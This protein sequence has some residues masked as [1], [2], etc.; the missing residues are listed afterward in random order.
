MFRSLELRLQHN[1]CT[2]P[3]AAKHTERMKD[4]L[5]SKAFSVHIFV[6]LLLLSVQRDKLGQATMAT[7]V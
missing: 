7:V 5:N 4:E 2:K 3:S 6:S 1:A